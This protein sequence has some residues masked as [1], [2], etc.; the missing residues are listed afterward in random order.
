LIA[1]H[2]VIPE[3]DPKTVMAAKAAIH[4][5]LSKLFW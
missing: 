2:F 4:A 3:A 1:R 5:S